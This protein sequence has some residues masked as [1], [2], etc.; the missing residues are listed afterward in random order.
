M[1]RRQSLTI[2]MGISVLFAP[3]SFADVAGMEMTA[4]D[5]ISSLYL[6]DGT[7]DMGEDWGY[8]LNPPN[9]EAWMIEVWIGSDP[10]DFLSTV[11]TDGIDP[12]VEISKTV[13]NETDFAWTDFHIELTPNEGEG[14]LFIFEDS[15]S[16]DRF[17]DIEIMNNDDGSAVM[18]FFTDFGAGDTPVLFGEMVTFEYTFNISGDPDFGY[19]T[20]QLPT[21]EPTSLVLVLAGAALTLR[22]S[23]R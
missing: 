21:L 18:W 20:V 4:G 2:A 16:S 5:D 7:W 11:F 14:D 1:I 22:R 8:I 23:R 12:D 6:E 15:V 13:T 9:A 3:I 17:S 10:V 19:R